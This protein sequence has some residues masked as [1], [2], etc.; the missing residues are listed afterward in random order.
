MPYKFISDPTEFIQPLNI[1]RLE[2]RVLRLPAPSAVRTREM[3]VLYGHHSSIERMYTLAAEFNRYG[4]VTM[5]DWPGLGGM[6][7]LFS[8]GKKPDINTMADYLAAF[9]KLRYRRRRVTIVGISY[10][11][12]V[13]TNMLQ[14]YP[15]LAAKVDF[16][17]SIAG[18]A[19]YDDFNFKPS[20]FRLMKNSTRVLKSRVPSKLARAVI[21]GYTVQKAYTTL[22]DKNAKM[23]DATP[24]Q[25][26]ERIAFEKKLW[27]INDMRTH[28]YTADSMFKIDLCNKQVKLPVYHVAIRDDQYLNNKLVEQHLAV[29]Y[30]SVQVIDIKLDAHMPTIVATPKEVAPFIPQKLRRL[31]AAA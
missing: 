3:L 20:K 6:S 24:A 13:A 15:E 14:R 21:N 1:N 4:P 17:V 27:R 31:L 19:R 10:G 18:F 8:I 28:F 9:V 26:K 23:K 29:I 12:A 22:A 25:L 11:F 7:S 16:V 2:G 5:P 30:A